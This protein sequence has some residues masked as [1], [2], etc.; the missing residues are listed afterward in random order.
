MVATRYVDA[1]LMTTM[2]PLQNMPSELQSEV[3][4]AFGIVPSFLRALQPGQQRLMWSMMRDF[5]MSSE[6]VLDGKTKQLIGLAVASQI[7]C[8]YCV[9]FHTEGARMD[10]ASEAEIQEAIFMAATTRLGSTVLNGVQVDKA[11]FQKELKQMLEFASQ[12][13]GTPTGHHA[14]P[15]GRVSSKSRAPA[16]KASPKKAKISVSGR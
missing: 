11:T 1:V 6:T 5:E 4:E 8:E 14:A 2:N 10:G 7:P 13:S 15:A 9:T 3:K 12:H 16:T